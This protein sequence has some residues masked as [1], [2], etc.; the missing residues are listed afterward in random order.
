VGGAFVVN[1]V[2]PVDPAQHWTPST[3]S[4]PPTHSS[5]NII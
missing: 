2:W 3:S 1:P 4:Y 5:S